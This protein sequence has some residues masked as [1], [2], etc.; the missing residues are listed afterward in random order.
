MTSKIDALAAGRSER[1]VAWGLHRGRSRKVL[2]RVT[3]HAELP[4][5]YQ[6]EWPDLGLSDLTNLTRA[7][8]AAQERAERQESKLPVSARRPLIWLRDGDH[9]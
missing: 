7:K 1:P 4:H 3:P 9:Q 5:L 2:V 6:I 8:A